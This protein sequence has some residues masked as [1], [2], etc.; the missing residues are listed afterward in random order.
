MMKAARS[1]TRRIAGRLIGATV[2]I[3]LLAAVLTI[4]RPAAVWH[5]LVTIDGRLLAVA[6]LISA[7]FLATRGLRLQLLLEEG[8][9]GWLR[10]TLVA[11]AAQGAALFAPAR[12]GEIALPWLLKR[13]AKQ[14]FS[15]GA[16]RR[17]SRYAA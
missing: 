11:A 16:A 8:H 3:A 17:C 1:K 2:A 7:A 6:A 5:L 14:D 10:A 12:T 9:L 15:C 13:T 4:A